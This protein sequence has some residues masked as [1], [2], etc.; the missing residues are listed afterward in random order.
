MKFLKLIISLN[1]FALSNQ[2]PSITLEKAPK[3]RNFSKVNGLE[4]TNLT[5]FENYQYYGVISIG[6]P[7]QQFKVLFDT[8]SSDLWI[9]SSK[10]RLGCS[11]FALYYSQYSETYIPD[12]YNQK[13]SLRIL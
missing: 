8:G 4:A 11:N 7:K 10:C 6:T 3:F 2:L 13:K 1:I 12:G 9:P 5:N